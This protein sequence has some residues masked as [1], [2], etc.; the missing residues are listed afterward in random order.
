MKRTKHKWNHKHTGTY[1]YVLEEFMMHLATVK[2]NTNS[3]QLN[4]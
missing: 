3:L 1:L 2:A 4:W